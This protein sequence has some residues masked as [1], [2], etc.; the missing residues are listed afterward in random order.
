[1][2]EKKR[3]WT[4]IKIKKYHDFEAKLV[5]KSEKKLKR[6]NRKEFKMQMLE[7]NKEFA[8]RAGLNYSNYDSTS[9]G[10]IVTVKCEGFGKEGSPIRPCF[11]RARRI[12]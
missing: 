12:G 2:Y 9:P 6:G 11:F 1:M 4:M 8:L 5:S 10:S 7:N 3:T